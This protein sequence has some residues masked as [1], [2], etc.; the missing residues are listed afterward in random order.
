MRRQVIQL[1]NFLYLLIVSTTFRQSTQERS[2]PSYPLPDDHIEGRTGVSV[3]SV[4]HPSVSRGPK[5]APP[6]PEVP[7]VGCCF[8][9]WLEIS[10]RIAVQ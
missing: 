5:A 7:E 8:R 6:F 9:R 1:P 4:D 10:R 2:D 3:G